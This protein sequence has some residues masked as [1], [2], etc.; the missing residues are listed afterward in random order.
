MAP[1]FSRYIILT[2]SLRFFRHRSSAAILPYFDSYWPSLPSAS[3]SPPASAPSSASPSACLACG[4]NVQYEKTPK[5]LWNFVKHVHLAILW[6]RVFLWVLQLF[7]SVASIWSKQWWFQS[8][9]HSIQ[10]TAHFGDKPSFKISWY[11]YFLWTI[12]S[13]YIFHIIKTPPH[14]VKPLGP[15]HPPVC[16]AFLNHPGW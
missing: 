2:D 4:Q 8:L 16:L 6:C 1:P 3:S 14:Q 11:T 10:S 15:L 9:P 7:G 13:R 5:K 12:T